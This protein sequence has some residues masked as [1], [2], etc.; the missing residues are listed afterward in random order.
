MSHIIGIDLSTTGIEL[1]G[2]DE[3]TNLSFWDHIPLRGPDA[4]ERLRDVPRKLPRWG[5]W[6]DDVMLV[7]IEAPWGRNHPGTLAKLSRVFGAILTCI[8]PTVPQVMEIHP[9]KWR[10]GIGLPGN[11]PKKTCAA[12]A[13][14]LGAYA[15]WKCQD[16]YDAFC[17]AW[18]ARDTYFANLNERKTA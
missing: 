6:W 4:L 12:K 3:N 13:V 1:V 14:E 18:V 17:V 5:S 10:T 9:T 15:D 11:A 16:A 2:L 7:A 8:P